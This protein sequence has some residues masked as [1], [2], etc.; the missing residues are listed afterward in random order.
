MDELLGEII[1]EN[2]SWGEKMLHG[3]LESMGLRVRRDTLRQSMKRVDPAGVE[4][5]RHRALH[6][7]QYKVAGPNA[8]W[9]IDGH[10]KLIR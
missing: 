10:H 2:P 6:R 5:R 3:R 9:H 8:L 4:E 7:R 1:S